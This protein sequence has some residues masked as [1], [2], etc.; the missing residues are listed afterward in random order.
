MISIIIVNYNG[1]DFTVQ[2]LR[3]L[4]RIR[5]SVPI[6]TIVVDN[7][8]TDGSVEILRYEFP[9][10]ILLPQRLNSGFGKANNIG[11]RA[12]HGEHLFF[13]NNDTLFQQDIIEPL[14]I[15]LDTHKSAGIV[16][17]M[18]L[19]SDFTYQLSYG[20]FPSLMNE[21][22]TKRDTALFTNIP[23]DRSPRQVDWVSFAAV[24]IRRSA[25]EKVNGFDE[26]YFMYF[27]DADLCFRLQNAGYQSF[28]CAE[29]SLIH[30]GGGSRSH[31]VTNM[32]K[33]EYRR[34]QLLFYASHRSWFELLALR[35]YLLFRFSYPFLCTRGEEHH[36]ARSVISMA[37]SSYAHRS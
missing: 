12:A 27:E 35:F 26:R 30:R 22:R 37:L 18:L 14:N 25:F 34:S 24:M 10:A 21:L 19:N 28:Y 16:A 13:V 15:F 3:S 17:P 6:E 20:K 32:I 33:T 5:L 8:S 23:K 7:A 31:G 11:A 36:R 4:E 9:H 2:C 1:K 29:Y